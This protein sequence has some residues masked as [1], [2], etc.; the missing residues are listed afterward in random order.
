MLFVVEEKG[1]NLDFGDIFQQLG[2]LTVGF[3]AVVTRVNA[4]D[5]VK[6]FLSGFIEVGQC[7]A[8]LNPVGF[9]GCVIH[10]V[11]VSTLF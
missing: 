11:T 2:E 3:S 6:V 8:D 10:D 5:I 4:A 9:A 7:H 1:R